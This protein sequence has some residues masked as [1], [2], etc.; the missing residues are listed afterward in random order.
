MVCNSSTLYVTRSSVSTDICQIC[1]YK[2]VEDVQVNHFAFGQVAFCLNHTE[3]GNDIF[4]PT[5]IRE[6]LP[7]VEIRVLVLRGQI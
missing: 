2:A 5:Q 6:P 7:K 4:L 3:I 1:I